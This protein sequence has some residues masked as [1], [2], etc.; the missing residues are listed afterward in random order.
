M[1]YQDEKSKYEVTPQNEGTKCF[2]RDKESSQGK[3]G[4]EWGQ[5]EQKDLESFERSDH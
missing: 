5:I 2:E 1:R 3:I 4:G